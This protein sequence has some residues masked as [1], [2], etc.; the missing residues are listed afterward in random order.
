MRHAIEVH[1]VSKS[2]EVGTRPPRWRTGRSERSVVQALQE[3]SMHVAAGEIF[4]LVGRNGYGKT[5]LIKCICALLEPSQGRLTVLGHD[6]VRE[7][8]AVRAVLGYVGADERSF[9]FRLSGRQNLE[10]FARLHGVSAER[11]RVRIGML[12]ERFEITSLLERRFYE[13]STGNRQRLAMVR[14]LLHDPKLL[15]LDEPT[16]SLDAFAAGGLRRT[17]REWVRE[18]AERSVLI[19]SHNLEEVEQLSQRVG[20]MTRGRL[21]Q[22][23]TLAELRARFDDREWVR[24]WLDGPVDLSELRASLEGLS[25]LGLHAGDDAL[26]GHFLE[27]RRQARDAL[28]DRVLRQLPRQG[29]RLLSFECR[30]LSLQDI[31]DRVDTGRPDQEAPPPR[32][33][34]SVAPGERVPAVEAASERP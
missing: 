23:G 28:L 8:Q 11:A 5:T 19:T 3:V 2:F 12:A 9:Y 22:C 15:V 21:S 17:L 16:R 14:A 27:F 10:F 6:V 20:I 18:D 33:R 29:R 31:V 34:L 1:A 4:G 32:E 25:V 24:L 30:E 26:H 7:A 13:Y